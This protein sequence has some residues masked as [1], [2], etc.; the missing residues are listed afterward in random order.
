M[1][2]RRGHTDVAATNMPR[3]MRHA[4][5]ARVSKAA[6]AVEDNAAR[7][8]REARLACLVTAAT[9]RRARPSP[10]CE[11]AATTLF[12]IDISD[13]SNAPLGFPRP[14][15]RPYGLICIPVLRFYSCLL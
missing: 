2:A 14:S 12:A 5:L 15:R 6:R 1:I 4:N 13:A 10:V 9:K 8:T 7:V 3:D 11:T